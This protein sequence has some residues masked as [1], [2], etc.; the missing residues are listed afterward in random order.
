M[1]S[2][3]SNYSTETPILLKALRQ[4][5]KEWETSFIATN[6]R[7]AEREDIKQVPEIGT[8]HQLRSPCVQWN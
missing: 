6:G 1:A 2:T 7:K 8:M 3:A 4:E 5:L